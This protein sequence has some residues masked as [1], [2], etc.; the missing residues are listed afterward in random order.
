MQQLPEGFRVVGQP[1]NTPDVIPLPRTPQQREESERRNREEGYDRGDRGFD[2]AAKLRTEFRASPAVK[3]YEIVLRT[4]NSAM[5]TK[6]TAEGDQSLIVTFARMLDPNSVVRD[7]EFATAAGN[8][9]AFTRIL[10]QV[11]RQFGVDG[12]G[13]LSETGRARLREEMRNL[14]I[15]G[16]KPNYDRTRREYEMLAQDN[17]ITPAQVVGEP[18]ENAFPKGLLSQPI[19]PAREVTLSDGQ[20][21]ISGKLPD[22]YRQEHYDYLRQNWGN[23]NPGE[24]AQF[25]VGLDEKY[26]V[27]EMGLRSDPIT[28][29]RFAPEANKYAREGGSPERINLP[30]PTRPVG[31]VEGAFNAAAR[32]GAGTAF[33]NASNA[34]LGG[35]PQMLGGEQFDQNAAL[36]R[37]LNPGFAQA[38]ELAGGVAGTMLGGGALK[39]GAA[40][41]GSSP[42]LASLLANPMTTEVGYGALYGASQDGAQGAVS[43][44]L[45]GALGSKLGDIAGRAF[46]DTFAGGAMDAA[47]DAVPSID[48]LKAQAGREYAAVEAAGAVADP[49][50]TADMFRR[51][52]DILTREGRM[53]PAGRLIDTDTP[54]TRAMTLLEDYAGQQMTPTQ[55][56]AVRNVLSEGLT[57]QDAAQK[58]ISGMLLDEF[59]TW[60]DPVLPGISV[61]RETA[62]RYLQGQQID[63]AIQLANA[64]KSRLTQSGYENALRGRFREMDRSTIR[65]RSRFDDQVTDAIE[66]VSRGDNISNLARSVGK[67]APTSPMAMTVGGGAVGMLGNMA[68][69]PMVGVPLGL[70]A[71]GAGSAG[72]ALATSRAEKAAANALNTALGGPQ[73]Q[74]MLQQAAEEAA[75]RG[76]RIGGGLFG[77]GAV[78]T[79]RDGF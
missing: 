48:D 14:V 31:A 59:D 11:K 15:N 51:A 74:A 76:R 54:T 44:A 75:M 29:A 79:S 7:T 30:D 62:S 64:D 5:T 55:A 65:G 1:A 28:Y 60:A 23:L 73:Y 61:P 9:D 17:G 63:E 53:S 34:A 16:Y 42:R 38:G 22:G 19:A 3:E 66:A 47:R 24:Y 58:R 46:P 33:A 27:A 70:L 32:S 12:A 71:A 68:G 36:L 69:G 6:P 18:V 78:V 10:T 4:F 21:T 2:N 45:G 57:G 43:G 35:I 26:N 67:F 41:A 20:T 72:R 8:E 52:T 50:A 49:Q 13:R 39:G 40:L 77:S 37:D 56:G 25:R